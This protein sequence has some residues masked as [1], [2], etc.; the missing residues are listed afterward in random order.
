MIESR[1]TR[2]AGRDAIRGHRPASAEG[3]LG[4]LWGVG[5]ARIAVLFLAGLGTYRLGVYMAGV[6][7]VLHSQATKRE[8][9]TPIALLC[10]I[11]SNAAR[12]LIPY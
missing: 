8:L 5:I 9:I 7:Y 12:F 3:P 2:P 1:T 10:G 11:L 4:W 6:G